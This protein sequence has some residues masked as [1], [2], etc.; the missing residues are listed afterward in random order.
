MNKRILS[1]YKIFDS[2]EDS[3]RAIKLSENFSEAIDYILGCK[4]KI[5]TTGMGKAGIAMK[6]FSATLCSVGFPSCFLHPGESSHGDLGILSNNDLLFVAST[7]GKTREIHEVIDL[8]KK[9]AQ[10]NIIGITSHPDS[11]IR[12]KVNLVLDMG[13]IKEAGHLSLA[14]T[15]SILVILAIT[16]ALALVAA[17]ESQLTKERYGLYHHGGYL[18]QI[19]RNKGI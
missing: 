5:I 1:A 9:I 3:I 14:P 15:N 12:E 6:K 11:P 4:G 2:F 17:E 16:D 10:I 8:S 7:S 13:I 18:G 19:A